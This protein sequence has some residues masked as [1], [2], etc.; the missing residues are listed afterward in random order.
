MKLKKII[1]FGCLVITAIAVLGDYMEWWENM[2]SWDWIGIWL[3]VEPI[4][5]VLPDDWTNREI[6]LWPKREETESKSV[7]ETSPLLTGL[8]LSDV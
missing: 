5:D 8:R 7:H 6:Q 4:M 3:V 1:A 2:E